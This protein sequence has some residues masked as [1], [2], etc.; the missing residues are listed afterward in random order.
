M[1]TTVVR[2]RTWAR[3][4]LP[5]GLAVIALGAWV[6]LIPLAGPS[7]DFGFDT[8]RTWQV[9]EQHVTLSI[10]PGVVAAVGGILIMLPARGRLGAWM[11]ALAA[12][13]LAVGPFLHPLWSDAVAPLATDEGKRAALWIAYFTGPAVLIA[14]LSGLSQGVRRSTTIVAPPAADVTP[15]AAERAPAESRPVS[16]P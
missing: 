7:F 9:T 12:A 14:Y 4:A 13:W 6:A 10:V 15:Q 1:T 2:R 11:A 5:L 16:L 8:D 3:I